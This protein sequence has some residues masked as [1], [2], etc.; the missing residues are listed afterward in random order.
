MVTSEDSSGR[1][2]SQNGFGAR[3]VKGQ[4][5][6]VEAQ[7]KC[8]QTCESNDF[9]LASITGT[10]AYSALQQPGRQFML[11]FGWFFMERRN[12]RSKQPVRHELRLSS[13]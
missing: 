10:K 6:D 11:K 3:H 8:L 5:I 9:K 4:R 7:L 12:H 13:R 1:S 2:H